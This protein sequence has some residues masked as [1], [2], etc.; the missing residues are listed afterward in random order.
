M[1]TYK[2]AMIGGRTSVLGFK[3]VGVETYIA[4]IPD[5]GSAIWEALPRERYAVVMITEP[6]YEAIVRKI[7]KISAS[8][9]LPVVLV[10]PAVTGSRGTAS[11]SLKKKIDKAVG[12]IVE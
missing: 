2:V 6:V 8:E 5:D 11:A 1:E 10:I 3:A 12:A 9:G 7:P 4:N